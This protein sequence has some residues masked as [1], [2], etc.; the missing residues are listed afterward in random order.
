MPQSSNLLSFVPPNSE[1][2]PRLGPAD[3]RSKL[4]SSGIDD[5]VLRKIAEAALSATGA[6]GAALA[7]RRNDAVLC[8]ARAGE[9][10]PPLGARL[11]DQS[12]ISGECLREGL[13]LR[14]ED[15]ET[16]TRVDAE[17][18]RSLGLRSLAVAAIRENGEVIG[19]LEVFSPKANTFTERHLEVLRQLAELAVE[20]FDSELVNA[21][22]TK[23]HL[24]ELDKPSEVQ[25]T[26]PE[27]FTP[28]MAATTLASPTITTPMIA[29][30]V[31]APVEEPIREK[32]VWTPTRSPSSNWPTESSILDATP[33]P[34]DVNIAAYMAAH[35]KSRAQTPVRIPKIWLVGLS[36]ITIASLVGWYLG[37]RYSATNAIVSVTAVAT[38]RTSAPATTD[39]TSA[40]N[41]VLTPSAKPSPDVTDSSPS[42]RPESKSE[43]D[44]LVNA[45]SLD[46]ISNSA[47]QHAR[48]IRVVS[49]QSVIDA[50]SDVVPSLT[51][52]GGDNKTGEAVS[53]LLNSPVSLPR[54][55]PPIS[56]GVEGGELETK[57]AALYPTQARAVRQQGTVVL[58]ALVGEDGLVKD[59]KVISGPPLLRQAASD[60]VKRWKYKPYKLN[61][62][63]ITAQTQ[64]EIY[65]KLD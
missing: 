34:G 33:L 42:D 46:R 31:A 8:I 14:C 60:A 32:P 15:T 26:Q 48:P 63:P 55:A 30:H 50:E 11:D 47:R 25:K 5:A 51:A 45:A 20:G 35:E 22:A 38:P 13:A 57:V 19:I 18:C 12:G 2:G 24:R 62:Q 54:R 6:Y 3:A 41:S 27:V 10:A 37:H 4:P 49:N 16:D 59:V 21:G 39:S 7:L 23:T 43:H 64:V 44:S 17:V 52:V 53:S 9:M 36:V 28:V 56:S 29:E 65:F 61:G 1:N 58:E 40:I